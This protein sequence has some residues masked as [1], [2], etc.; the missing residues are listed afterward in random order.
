MI[1]NAVKSMAVVLVLVL[2]T[3]LPVKVVTEAW[4]SVVSQTPDKAAWGF[5][6]RLHQVGDHDSFK[7]QR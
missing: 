6:L 2:C 1:D 7:R 5:E 4:R 3:G